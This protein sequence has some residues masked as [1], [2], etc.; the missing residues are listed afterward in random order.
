MERQISED[1]TGTGGGVEVSNNSGSLRAIM[2]ATDTSAGFRVMYN[3][4]TV[5]SLAVRSDG[6][7]AVQA[8]NIICETIN[9]NPV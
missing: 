4:K 7:T 9:G 8:Q 5:A 1:V 3:D 2:Q 6:Y